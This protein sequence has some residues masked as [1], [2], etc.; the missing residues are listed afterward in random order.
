MLSKQSLRALFVCGAG[1]ALAGFSA[2]QNPAKVG[3][4]N[5]QRALVETAE[6]KK[7]QVEMESKF[8][9]RSAEMEKVQKELQDI[10]SQLESGKLNPQGQQEL[11]ARGQRRQRELQ[12]MQEDLQGDVE[13]E[14]TD[15]LQRAGQ[16][17]TEVVK[18]IAEEKGL[19]VVVDAAN[20][21]FFR[22]TLDIT[23][24][25]IAAYDKAYPAK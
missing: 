22:P 23:T 17:M 6:I 8:R 25:A 21:V 7:A 5:L 15:V 2:A 13:R 12:R 24:E 1:L 19:D 20:T 14:R 16:R 11:T 3:I 4:I 9:P 18:K 10:Q